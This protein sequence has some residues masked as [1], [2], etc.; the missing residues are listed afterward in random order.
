[1]IRH[2]RRP[3][4][5]SPERVQ[6]LILQARE[7]LANLGVDDR[8]LAVE[9]DRGP[10]IHP[11][12]ALKILQCRLLCRGGKIV[13]ERL[14]NDTSARAMKLRLTWAVWMYKALLCNAYIL[15]DLVDRQRKIVTHK[16]RVRPRG[17]NRRSGPLRDR[18][19]PDSQVEH[20]H[21]LE[22]VFLEYCEALDRE[23]EMIIFPKRNHSIY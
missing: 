10:E 21:V 22:T 18:V 11:Q 17:Q 12:A 4:N 13:T 5:L 2:A 23:L 3:L 9:G 14:G 8:H 6:E 1:V 19:Q 7:Q 15:V 16:Q 20:L